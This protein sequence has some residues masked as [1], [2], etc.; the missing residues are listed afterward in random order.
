MMN[1]SSHN[2]KTLIELVDC[3]LLLFVSKFKNSIQSIVLNELLF[4]SKFKTSIQS[5]VHDDRILM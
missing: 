3:N 5:V 4:V 1:C 2:G